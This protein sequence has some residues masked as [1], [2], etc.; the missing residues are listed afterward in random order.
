MLTGI[1]PGLQPE[2]GVEGDEGED[3]EEEQGEVPPEGLE[4][5]AAEGAPGEEDQNQ[6]GLV[7]EGQ[8]AEGGDIGMEEEADEADAGPSQ[9]Q[10]AEPEQQQGLNN[11][12][13]F[14][15]QSSC[16]TSHPIST[17]FNLPVGPQSLDTTATSGLEVG[18]LRTSPPPFPSHHTV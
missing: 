18:L 17:T 9:E 2:V 15:P 4:E 5:Q 11:P 14:L 7:E 13:P 16:P 8:Y 6:Q 1:F 10:D 12:C 3:A